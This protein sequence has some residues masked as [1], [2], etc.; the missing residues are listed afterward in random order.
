MHFRKRRQFLILAESLLKA[1][2]FPNNVSL[3]P[4]KISVRKA[5]FKKC[6]FFIGIQLINN[7][8]LV[9]GVQQSDSVIYVP[10]LFSNYFPNQ[11]VMEYRAEFPVLHRGSLL[12]IHF[13]YGNVYMSIPNSLT[14]PLS[15]PLVTI[16]SFSKSVSLF[17]ICK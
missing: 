14:N 16:S 4:C 7:V 13:T 17:L 5:F 8:V 12:V 2:H 3:N 6:Y 9:S 15:S 10:I 11:V 1:R